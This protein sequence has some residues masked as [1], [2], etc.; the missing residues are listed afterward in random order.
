[1]P[2]EKLLVQKKALVAELAAKLKEAKGVVL[3][4]YRGLTVEQDTALRKAM[5]EAGVEYKVMKNSIIDFA[6]KDSSLGGL[7]KY[8]A[9]PTAIAIS[10]TD[11]VAPSKLLAK[12]SKD[13]DKLQIKGGAVEGNI[14]DENGVKEL[15]ST[16]SR[17]ELLG[18]LVGSLSGPLFGLAVAL[19][20]IVEKNEK[21]E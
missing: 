21:S 12:F 10:T 18:R 9:G 11:P 14:I 6:S 3:A 8:L 13:Y 4:D 16:P 5:R 17:E 19:N 15:A 2:S 7:E 20:A 1:M